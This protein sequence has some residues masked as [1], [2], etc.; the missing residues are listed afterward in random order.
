VEGVALVTGGG[1]FVGANLVRRL[2]NDGLEVHVVLH[3]EEPPWRLVDVGAITRHRCSISD[4]QAVTT[5]VARTKPDWIFHLAAHGAYSHQTDYE[6]MVAVN[7]HGTINLL[8]AA[9]RVGC[10]G[11]VHTGSSSEYGFKDHAPTED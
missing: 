1:G 3:G 11:F 2:V 7:T 6:R 8:A 5:V 9:A 10:H 4:A